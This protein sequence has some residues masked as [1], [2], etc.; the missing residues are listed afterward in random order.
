MMM[1]D[2]VIIAGFL[3]SLAAGLGTGLGAL[4]IFVRKGWS[5]AAQVTL[6]GGAGGVMLGA[7]VF[8]LAVPALE[9]FELRTGTETGAVLRTAIAIL[10]GALMIW[11]LH[12]F[13]PHAHLRGG[14]EGPRSAVRSQFSSSLISLHY[15]A[16]PSFS[17]LG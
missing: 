3:G 10:A 8:S 14:S 7:T 1:G 15:S 16:R 13:A 2:S 11:A 4:A 5:P 17:V 6:L 12:T 9:I